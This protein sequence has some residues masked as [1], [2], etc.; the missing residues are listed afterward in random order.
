MLGCGCEVMDETVVCFPHVSN[1]LIALMQVCMRGDDLPLL[2]GQYLLGY[3]ST[4]M[5]SIV[6]LSPTFQVRYRSTAI[7][8][9]AAI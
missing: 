6:G 9:A 5:Q 4:N 3:Y 1:A 2:S 8:T 7:N